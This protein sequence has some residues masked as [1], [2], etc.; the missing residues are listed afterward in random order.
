[1][2]KRLVS[3]VFRTKVT[4]PMMNPF[5]LRCSNSLTRSFPG[6][7][8]S[9]L[10]SSFSKNRDRTSSSRSSPYSLAREMAIP[11]I[12]MVSRQLESFVSRHHDVEFSESFLDYRD[13]ESPVSVECAIKIE[14]DALRC[15]EG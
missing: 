9:I 14:D 8:S 4:I 7:V 6:P 11:L 15:Q 3:R 5:C 12:L 1:M 13:P 2:S 10:A